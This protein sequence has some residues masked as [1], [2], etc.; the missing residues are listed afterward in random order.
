MEIGLENVFLFCISL[1]KIRR[2]ISKV[3]YWCYD[4]FDLV[5]HPDA[6]VLKGWSP[7]SHSWEVQPPRM[8]ISRLFIVARSF[9]KPQAV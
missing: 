6:Y 8:E 5:C 4:S 9:K 2:N 1:L 3:G 7:A